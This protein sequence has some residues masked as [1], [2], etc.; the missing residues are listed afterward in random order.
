MKVKV[1]SQKDGNKKRK[2]NGYQRQQET[3]V[4]D[5]RKAKEE[6]KDRKEE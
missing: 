3:A 5:A 4:P 6:K 2:K 1:K